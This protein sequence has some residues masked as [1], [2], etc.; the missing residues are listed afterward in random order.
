MNLNK[1]DDFYIKICNNIAELS[2]AQKMKVGAILVK[3]TNIISYV[4]N[5][6]PHG[7]D[8]ECEFEHQRE[9]HTKQE[10]VHAEM[11]AILKAAKQ[12]VSTNT[13][14]MYCSYSPC[15]NCAK[16][17]IQAGIKKFIYKNKYKK[18]EGLELLIK[19]NIEILQW[20]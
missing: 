9:L 11:N 7:F 2:H 1:W 4:Y 3:D 10:V 19:A 16:S 8:N 15:I 17:I 20:Q 14:I 6:T 13:S 12:G 18:S 5:G